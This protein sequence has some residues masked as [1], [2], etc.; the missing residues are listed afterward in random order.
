MPTSIF[1]RI[2]ALVALLA[3]F[4]PATTSAKPA[5]P[6]AVA[7]AAGPAGR[8]VVAP[9]GSIAKP[10]S[11]GLLV[12]DAATGKTLREVAMP[13]VTEVYQT[14]LPG[15]L[16]ARA[17]A[18]LYVVDVDNGKATRLDFGDV[19]SAEVLPNPIQTRGTAGKRF[20]LLGDA[21]MGNAFL[22]DLL[23]GKVTNLVDLIGSLPGAARYAG[24]AAVSAD[25]AHVVIWDGRHAFLAPTD[26]LASIEQVGGEGFVFG[27]TFTADGTALIYS[28][29]PEGAESSE[30]VVQPLDGSAPRII[31]SSKQVAITLAVPGRN[32]LLVDDRSTTSPGGDLSLLDIKSEESRTLLDYS[33]SVLSVQFSP[34]GSK[35]LAGIDDPNGRTWTLIDLKT[36]DHQQ[37]DGAAEADAKP[38]LY[39]IANWTLFTPIDLFGVGTSG[40][41]Y[42]G[43]SLKTGVFHKFFDTE[44]DARYERPQLSADGR[45]ALLTVVTKPKSV[46]W[47]L[48]NE[49]GNARQVGASLGTSAQFSP[50]AC[51]LAISESRIVAGLRTTALSL[52]STSGKQERELGSGLVLAWLGQGE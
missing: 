34:D 43:M 1:I 45:L 25:D 50:D 18:D 51:W 16:I 48:D 32:A 44:K 21:A 11:A 23:T 15:H 40:G 12:I 9:V 19:L 42:G 30:I 5:T 3:G 17:G 20:F 10:G 41:F 49:T 28:R 36:G 7:C 52:A 2:L 27:P 33:G 14:A 47:L 22:V 4:A 39:G 46:V 26:D 38:G 6:T 13:L 35:A 29:Q 31:H 8:L 24:Y 37:I